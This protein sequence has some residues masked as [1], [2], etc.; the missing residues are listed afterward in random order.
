MRGLPKLTD[1]VRT[2][3]LKNGRFLSI[4][5]RR[6]CVFKIGGCRSWME[7]G[8]GGHG[9]VREVSQQY[10]SRDR[11]NVNEGRR[12]MT[13]QYD[14]DRIDA[15][16][17]AKSPGWRPRAY[18]G[19]REML[20]DILDDQEDIECLLACRWGDKHAWAWVG[21]IVVP[22]GGSVQNVGNYY[23]GPHYDGVAVATSRRVIFLVKRRGFMGFFG[24]ATTVAAE[25]PYED[26]VSVPYPDMDPYE[27]RWRDRRMG[28]LVKIGDYKYTINKRID[29]QP[30]IDYV[31]SH[32]TSPE[33]LKANRL[34][35][36][37]QACAPDF[38]D[39]ADSTRVRRNLY[40]VL[41]DYENI[42][43]LIQ[44]NLWEWS[45]PKAGVAVA[46]ESRIIFVRA[47][48]QWHS[49]P[50]SE[51]PY[52]SIDVVA[53]HQAD[54]TI[55]RRSAGVCKITDARQVSAESFADCIQD[56]LSG[57]VAT[58][59]AARRNRIDAQ[60]HARVSDN[61]VWRPEAH[62]EELL[63]LYDILDDAEDI[64]GVIEA[65]LEDIIYCVAVATDRRVIVLKEYDNVFESPYE[66]IRE[67]EY[68]T[69]FFGSRPSM[70]ITGVFTNSSEV[71]FGYDS[72]ALKAFADCAQSHLVW[73]T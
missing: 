16:W 61:R 52:R 54:V 40:S 47:S 64:E 28:N 3:P 6:R 4:T 13:T 53:Y 24:E 44:G 68:N 60:W 51:T 5:V 63:A 15:Q 10:Q 36:Q 20:Y 26:I 59:E 73:T 21:N 23:P 8:C 32:L 25:M 29:D 37:W 38:F 34:D 18:S 43:R 17:H 12:P 9:Q 1:G 55:T 27:R 7:L 41:Y 50:W 11:P 72:R 31:R 2:G 49:I 58:H 33:A 39:P 14:I 66:S 22:G 30:F 42:E 69:E 19:E 46:T 57:E 67:I 56:H 45:T 62:T 70:T 48:E 71:I 35:A 65:F